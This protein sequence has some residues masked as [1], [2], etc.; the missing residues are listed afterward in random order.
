MF[1]F[2]ATFNYGNK[3]KEVILTS[4]SRMAALGELRVMGHNMGRI[5]NI[6]QL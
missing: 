6:K 4:N 1:K 2:L 3:T 5:A